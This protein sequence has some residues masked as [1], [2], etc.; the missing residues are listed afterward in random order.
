MEQIAEGSYYDRARYTAIGR[1]HSIALD[2]STT[3]RGSPG[4]DPFKRA[5]SSSTC[6]EAVSHPPQWM[7]LARR[8]RGRQAP[9][10]PAAAVGRPAARHPA[11]GAGTDR[12]RADPCS[13]T[14]THKTY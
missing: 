4:A 6:A 7:M 11:A 12:G 5:S 13:P 2:C 10:T 9:H 1:Y 8:G 3:R 14:A